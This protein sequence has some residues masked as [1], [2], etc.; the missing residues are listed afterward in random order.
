MV[1]PSSSRQYLVKTL[2]VTGKY[3]PY[4]GQH[5]LYDFD[6]AV[7]IAAREATQGV[8]SRVVRFRDD[9][10]MVNLT[11]VAMLPTSQPRQI[12]RQAPPDIRPYGAQIVEHAE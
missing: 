2:A 11:G 4:Q 7:A 6:T 5:I 3:V 1:I 10:V 12:R 8:S 9:Q